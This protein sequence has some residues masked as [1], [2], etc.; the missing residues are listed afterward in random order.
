MKNKDRAL[1]AVAT[2][3]TGAYHAKLV[4]QYAIK[5]N[6]FYSKDINE[7]TGIPKKNIPRIIQ[8]L[9]HAYGFVFDI[10]RD[11]SR[12]Y[13]ELIDCQFD[14]KRIPVDK[15]TEKTQVTPLKRPISADP[16]WVALLQ[17][18]FG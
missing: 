2:M 15:R 11:G 12:F 9:I 1:K 3:T 4:A 10:Q 8:N 17:S 13:Y 14:G 5:H 7:A 16:L 6:K 18:E